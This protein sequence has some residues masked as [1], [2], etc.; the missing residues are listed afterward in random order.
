MSLSRIASYS[1]RFTRFSSSGLPLS[2]LR[3]TSI[4]TFFRLTTMELVRRTGDNV[5]L[6]VFEDIQPIVWGTTIPFFVICLT[7]CII[8][9]YTRAFIQKPFG[10]DDW[11][12]AVGSVSFSSRLM[13]RLWLIQIDTLD[14]SAIHRV[15]VDYSR[16]RAVS[17]VPA[18]ITAV[19]DCF[20]DT[21]PTPVSNLKI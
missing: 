18:L 1:E 9:L 13:E 16:R 15:D 8:R 17:I 20:L 10:I 4:V 2:P 12:M 5:N 6:V 3:L 11:F 7:S 14:R 21:L 19:S